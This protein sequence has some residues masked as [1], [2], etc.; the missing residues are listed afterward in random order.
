MSK[1]KSDNSRRDF[2][3][4]ASLAMGG[5]YILPRHVLG[6][7]DSLHQVINYKLPALAL[8]VK[9]KAICFR[10]TKVEKQTLLFYAM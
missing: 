2:I 5:F 4:N 7:K 8:A 1:R 3:R 9:E 10:F 6:G